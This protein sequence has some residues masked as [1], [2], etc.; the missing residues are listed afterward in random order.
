MEGLELNGMMST[1]L[2]ES[3]EHL[4]NW[5]AQSLSQLDDEWWKSLVVPKLSCQQQQIV[6]RNDIDNLRALD[7]AAL[8]RILDQNWYQISQL[9]KLSQ[10]D[11][12][13]VKEM[14]SVRNRWAHLGAIGVDSDDAYRDLD[15]LQRFLLVIG[16]PEV[17]I[18][19]IKA[20]KSSIHSSNSTNH[21]EQ[22]EDVRASQPKGKNVAT[23]PSRFDETIGE[24]S[25]VQ[26]KSD[27]TKQGV[28]L[29]IDGHGDSARCT[30]FL[31]GKEQQFYVSQ[32]EVVSEKEEDPTLS[33][34]DVRNLL[35]C[36]QIL[37]P[38]ISTLYSLNAAR[39]DFVPY[40]FR[41]ALKI[42]RSDR[43]RLLIADGVGVGKTIEAGLVLRELQA[44]RAVE[45]VLIICPKP[46][47][48]ERKWELEMKRFD[49]KFTHLD[50]PAL[51]F[52]IDE[53]DL[54]GEW[55]EQHTKA[56]IPYSLFDE[57][58]LFGNKEGRSKRIGLLELDPP[59]RFDLIIVDEAHHVRNSTTFAHQAVR[60][61]CE[62]AEA[63]IFLT[64]TPIQLGNKDLFT[65]LNLL[66]PDIVIDEETFRHMAEPNP[67]INRA[68]TSIRSGVPGWEQEAAVELDNAAKTA[69]GNAI[70]ERNPRYQ[71]I[72]RDLAE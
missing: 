42:I 72:Q 43:P 39:I 27:L 2:H 23:G 66:R 26:L 60:T 61:F 40:Q 50:G 24:K 6:N 64:A 5:L 49:E 67:H 41:P 19:N 46:L 10:Q 21:A 34:E 13:Y 15:T 31:D 56:I 1:L 65:L 51:R 54:E 69:W 8:L 3:A 17:L 58:F 48:A 12:N 44:R 62:N 71:A 53:T 33:V 70:L 63:V 57:K 7:L 52:C 9:K 35:T 16:A 29:R 20:H 47:V 32:I 45:S 37:H 59:P 25:I 28:V 38:S 22:R 68:L 30:V 36:L 11:R 18:S 14:Q 4:S 55:P